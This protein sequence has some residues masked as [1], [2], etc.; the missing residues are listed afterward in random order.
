MNASQEKFNESFS[1]KNDSHLSVFDNPVINLMDDNKSSKSDIYDKCKETLSIE[2]LSSDSNSVYNGT[3]SSLMED[4]VLIN[5]IIYGTIYCEKC[6]MPMSIIFNASLDLTFDCGCSLTKYFSIKE[7]INKYLYRG[8]IEKIN[9]NY[10]LHCKIHYQ[11]TK[12]ISYCQDCEYD[13][14]I[15]CLKDNSPSFLNATTNKKHINHTLINLNKIKDKFNNIEKLIKFYEQKM[16]LFASYPEE[17]YNTLKNIFTIIRSLME[18]YQKYKCYNSYKSLENAELFLE[19]I[20]NPSKYN[21]CFDEEKYDTIKLIKITS[22]DSLNDSI[23]KFTNDILAIIIKGSNSTIDLSAFKDKKFPNLKDLSLVSDHI[24]DISALFSC[25]FPNLEKFDLADNEID[26]SVIELLKVLNLKKLTYLNLFHNKITNLEIFELIENYSELT[27]F[28]IGENK[29]NY[30]DNSKPF[31]KF[32]EKLE[33]FGLTGNFEGEKAEFVEKLG[34]E[35]IK[36]F[37]FSRN[38]ITNLKYIKNIKFK[39]L[40]KIWAISNQISDI[41]EIMNIQNKE[42][43]KIINLQNNQI[44]NFN[45]LFDIIGDFPNLKELKLSN[46]YIYKSEVIEMRKKIKN[47]YNRNLNI[48]I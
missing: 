30:N 22:S 7:F 25:E 11:Q 6:N 17:K 13:L 27:T 19:K 23:E 39:R 35:N 10:L 21:F 42:N 8:K 5:S 18:T 3:F 37:Y 45:D 26:N 15:E 20:N 32:P 43:V 47:K 2:N 33:I 4:N 28:Y 24:K 48:I 29:F 40:E 34:I 9:N 31:Y 1:N 36:T 41:K 16:D 12:F 38:K 44:Y 14:C 46:N